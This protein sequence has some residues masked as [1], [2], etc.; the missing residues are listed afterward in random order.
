MYAIITSVGFGSVPEW[1]KGADC[2][3]VV[4]DFGG[5]N[6]PAPTK[7][8]STAYGR[9]FLFWLKVVVSRNAASLPVFA[10][11]E[12]AVDKTAKGKLYA[13]WQSQDAVVTNPPAPTK[14]KRLAFASLFCFIHCESNGISSTRLCR[15]ILHGILIVHKPQERAFIHS[16]LF[17]EIIYFCECYRN[18]YKPIFFLKF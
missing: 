10:K 17:G 11:G 15:L 16:L 13:A 12:M 6:P 8:M 14:Q 3:S 4:F 18:L 2:K 9:C 7:T 1:P 5:S